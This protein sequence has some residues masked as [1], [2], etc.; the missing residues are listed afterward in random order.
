MTYFLPI[1]DQ[2]EKECQPAEAWPSNLIETIQ[3]VVNIPC[4]KPA[5]PEF[6]FGMNLADA[7]MNFLTLTRKYGGDLS[8]AL[9]A[10]RNSPLGYGSEFRQ[11]NV[12]RKIFGNTPSGR[13]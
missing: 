5:A 10:Q 7:E 4:K 9:H 12:L 1:A 11:V 8:K 2:Q 13:G 3:E 6:R